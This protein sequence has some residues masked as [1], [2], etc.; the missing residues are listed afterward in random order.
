MMFYLGKHNIFFT[1]FKKCFGC[2]S[3]IISEGQILNQKSADLLFFSAKY[4]ERQ[5]LLIQFCYCVAM[6]PVGFVRR[7]LVFKITKRSIQ[8]MPQYVWQYVLHIQSYLSTHLQNTQIQQKR[9]C[10][11]TEQ[12][13]SQCS[14]TSSLVRLSLPFHCPPTLLIL[15]SSKE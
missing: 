10:V 4:S 13:T 1:G 14:S 8:T 2:T 6:Y 12:L 15:Y 3:P 5:G 11:C 7:Q 9:V